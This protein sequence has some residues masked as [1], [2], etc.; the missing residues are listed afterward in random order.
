MT[1]FHDRS[2]GDDVELSDTAFNP[3]TA[4]YSGTAYQFQ[5]QNQATGEVSRVGRGLADML[6]R[7]NAINSGSKIPTGSTANMSTDKIDST[8]SDTSQQKF[9]PNNHGNQMGGWN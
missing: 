7:N 4:N 9:I 8:S 6:G 3:E 5:R 1:T 2:S